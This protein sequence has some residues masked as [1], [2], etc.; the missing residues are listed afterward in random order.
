MEKKNEEMEI[1]NLVPTLK[2]GG[3]KILVWGCISYNGVG[4]LQ[5]ISGKTDSLEYCTILS[6]NLFQSAN[7]LG[8]KKFVFQQDN[9]PKHTSKR[10][11]EFFSANNVELMEWPS[12]SPDLNPIEHV[13]DH[14]Q[15]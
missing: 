2:F 4:N 12:Q 5:F 9:D 13:W 6:K 8:L 14:I 1:R 11:K 7:K 3:G 10:T 15:R